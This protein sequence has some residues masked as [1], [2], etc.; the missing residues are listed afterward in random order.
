MVSSSATT[1]SVIGEP[2]PSGLY[3]YCKDVLAYKN[4]NKL[5]K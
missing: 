3:D 2:Q 5:C 1:F 4:S